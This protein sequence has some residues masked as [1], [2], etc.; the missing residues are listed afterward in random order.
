MTTERAAKV[1][2]LVTAQMVEC[3]PKQAPAN[4]D[5]IV[6]EIVPASEAPETESER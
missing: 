2:D 4:V 3:E 5:G 1:V 6:L